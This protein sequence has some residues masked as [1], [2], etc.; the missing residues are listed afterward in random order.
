MTDVIPS[1]AYARSNSAYVWKIIPGPYKATTSSSSTATDSSQ[2]MEILMNCDL[3]D[4]EWVHDDS[5]PLYKQGSCSDI[6]Q[7][8]NCF[9]TGRPDTDYQKMKW[10]PKGCNLPRLDGVHILE[11]L[12]GKRLVFVGDS[13]NR[14]MWE[15]LLC[16]LK[17]STKDPSNVFEA[18]GRHHFRGETSYS[19]I[20]K[21]YNFSVEFFIAPFFVQE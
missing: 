19:F 1:S 14:N 15:S 6:D 3:F 13:L 8:F 20:F 9:Y 17:G 7:E 18:N 11:L 4:G 5:Y 16:I 10:K 12:R 2:E 21:D